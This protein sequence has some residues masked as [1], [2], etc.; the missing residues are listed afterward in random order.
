MSQSSGVRRA[1]GSL[2]FPSATGVVIVRSEAFA[3]STVAAVRA[4]CS[5]CSPTG[6]RC[7]STT[8]SCCRPA[9]EQLEVR[10]TATS[11]A[12]PSRVQF[13]Y[14]LEGADAGLGR[15]RAAPRRL[16]LEPARRP[17]SLPRQGR[18]TA[19]ASGARTA[20]R[21]RGASSC[22]SGRRGGSTG[23][24]ASASCSASSQLS[25]FRVRRGQ[26]RER[27]LRVIVEERTAE[28]SQEITERRASRRR[29]AKSRDELEDR[30]A[31]ADHRAARRLRADAEGHGGAPPAGRAARAGAEAREHRPARRRRRPRHQQ[32]ADRRP[33]LLGSGRRRPGPVASAAGAAAADPQGGGAR[34]EPDPSPARLRAQADRRAARHQPERADAEP[35]RHAAAADR[36]GR[37]AA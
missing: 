24:A 5:R 34:L 17:L 20:P 36:R 9:S 30:V 25:R 11:L 3:K 22:S 37:R 32:R 10:Y 31:R 35:R 6:A 28:L 29:C 16:L 7:R 14:K 1:D 27:A 13:S 4:R 23:S 15:R 19:T 21:C 33:Q 26:A 12:V 2:A 8:T 18:P